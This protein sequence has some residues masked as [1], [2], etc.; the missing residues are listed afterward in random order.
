MTEFGVSLVIGGVAFAVTLVPVVAYLLNFGVMKPRPAPPADD[1]DYLRVTTRFKNCFMRDMC[2]I[3][4]SL[5]LYF[6][7]L[8]RGTITTLTASLQLVLF[9]IYAIV[10][11]F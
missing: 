10:V 2:F 7:A 6:I 1:P 8:E 3:M 11:Y 5:T 4:F 9:L